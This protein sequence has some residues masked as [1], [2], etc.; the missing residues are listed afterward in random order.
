[1]SDA[2]RW[3][4]ERDWYINASGTPADDG[5]PDWDT[6]YA[7]ADVPVPSIDEFPDCIEVAEIVPLQNRGIQVPG[8]PHME[9]PTRI[10]LRGRAEPDGELFDTDR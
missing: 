4:Y 6:Y 10:V 5:G 8:S 7:P 1:M 2:N 3:L 9:N